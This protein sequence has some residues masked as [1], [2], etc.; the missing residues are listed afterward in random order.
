MKISQPALAPVAQVLVKYLA[1]FE[2]DLL[3]HPPSMSP[4]INTSESWKPTKRGPVTFS[5]GPGHMSQAPR[6]EGQG[7]SVGYAISGAPQLVGFPRPKT[8]RSR[9]FWMIP[10]LRKKKQGPGAFGHVMRA[11]AAVPKCEIETV[12]C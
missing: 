11:N 5:R 3:A 1:R 9:P 6:H 2:T 12:P 8:V 4:I 10:K 7:T